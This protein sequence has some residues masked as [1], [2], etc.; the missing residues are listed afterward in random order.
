MSTNIN[1]LK[2]NLRKINSFFSKI[3]WLYLIIVSLLIVVL[4][5]WY[6]TSTRPNNAAQTSHFSHVQKLENQ[7]HQQQQLI[8]S[9]QKDINDLKKKL[10]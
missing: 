1:P 6:S 7:I 10:P 9:M 3:G 5:Q 8:E 4:V 2:Q